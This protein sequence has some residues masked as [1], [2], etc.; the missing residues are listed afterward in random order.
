MRALPVFATLAFLS[1]CTQIE[2]PATPPVA[3]TP[4]EVATSG[5]IQAQAISTVPLSVAETRAFLE[6]NPIIDFLEPTDSIS[7]PVATDILSG[8]WPDVGAVRRVELADGH[9]VI[10]RIIE[11]RPEVFR[12]QLFL[13]TNSTGR[14]VDQIVGEQRFLAQPDGSTRIEWD[15]NVKPRNALAGIFVRQRINEID[16]YITGGLDGLAAAI[17]AA[18]S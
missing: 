15:Y 7:N 5:F 6:A 3:P 4:P 14:G 9:Y 1:A 8:R 11:N 10:E 12:Y 2:P 18:S 17:R 16:S 13:F